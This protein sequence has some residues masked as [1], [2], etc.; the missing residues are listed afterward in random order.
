MRDWRIQSSCKVPEN[1]PVISTASFRPRDWYPATVPGPV[2]ANLVADNLPDYP[3]PTVG[4]NLRKLPGMEYPVGTMFARR[5]MPESSPFHCSWWYRAE[6]SMPAADQGRQNWLNFQ[7]INYR[8]NI[9]L[10]GHRIAEADQV[11]GAWRTY[12]FNVTSSLAYGTANVLAV[13][14][15]A[16]TENDLAITFVDWNPMPPDKDMGLWREV[17]IAGSGPVALRHPFV[18]T[19]FTNAALDAAD[20]T[21]YATVKN[22]SSQTVKGS[23][24]VSIE[25]IRVV[26]DFELPAGESREI[27][28]S[29]D[30]YPQLHVKN[31]RIWWPARLGPQNLYTANIELLGNGSVSDT[32]TISFGMREVTSEIDGEGHRLF[33][34][35]RQKILVRGAGWTSDMLLRSNDK[36]LEQEMKYALD[37]GLN[38]LRLEGKIESGHFFDLA[39]RMGMLVMAGWSCCDFWEKW[40]DWQPKDKDIASESLRSQLLRLRSHPSLLTWLN[41]SDYPPVKEIEQRYLDLEK[42][43]HWPTPILSSSSV[44]PS[45]LT[46]P[47]GV[48]STGPYDY[49]P[50][51]FWLEDTRYGGAFGFNTETSPG[52]AIPPPQSIRKFI[53]AEHLW[54]IDD[55]WNFH[56]GAGNFKEL[57]IYAAALDRRYGPSNSMEEFSLKSQAAA[58]EGERAMFEAYAQNRYTSTGVVQWMLNNAWPSMIWHLYDWYLMPGGGYFGAKKANEPLHVQY[59]RLENSIY[60]SNSLSRNFPQMKVR[61]QVMNLDMTSKLDKQIAL[62]VGPDSVTRVLTMPGISGL[63]STYFLRLRLA[64][65]SGKVISDNFYWLSTQ[66]DILDWDQESWIYTPAKQLE[67]F[68]AL[69]KLPRVAL[70][71]SATAETNGDETVLHITVR[72]L[73]RAL[74]FQVHLRVTD[75]NDQD[76]LPVLLEDN[77]FP[78]FP[79]EERVVTVRFGSNLLAGPPTVVVEGWNAEPSRIQPRATG[80][81]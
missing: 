48:K 77:Y 66:P 80:L 7:G 64:D 34:I 22:G 67:D 47:S 4:M 17:F 49:V 12:E 51:S 9:W 20:L 73:G 40:E 68:T 14:V 75:S 78:L 46:G 74:A 23:M 29:P 39:D 35:N 30:R 60:V 65:A 45:Q 41:G 11:A 52:A 27:S 15:F 70:K 36:R 81:K 54:P 44:R 5:P 13:E 69:Q 71:A 10:N 19:K 63:T 43:V 28:F 59:S 8:A 72:N 50:P 58:Y 57:K 25:N 6:F 31:P 2:V 55:V 79:G 38:T 21:I 1:G 62:D 53:P 26:Q 18:D 24:R 3:D 37:M 16:P 32:Q 42:Q 56:A 61:F 33:R 76:V